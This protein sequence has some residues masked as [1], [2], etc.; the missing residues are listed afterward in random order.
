MKFIK[1]FKEF[2]TANLNTITSDSSKDDGILANK[3]PLL[4]PV[5]SG[6]IIDVLL[7]PWY[8]GKTASSSRLNKIPRGYIVESLQAYLLVS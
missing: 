1:D 5:S 6:K 2:N 4:E 7:M 3:D 8:A